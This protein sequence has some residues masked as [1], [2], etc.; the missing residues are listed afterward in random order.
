MPDK[1]IVVDM[2]MFLW[3]KCKLGIQRFSMSGSDYAKFTVKISTNKVFFSFWVINLNFICL[4]NYC[5]LHMFVTKLV[6]MLS[7]SFL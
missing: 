4:I 1:E 3:Q 2:I 6:F 5:N 7:E